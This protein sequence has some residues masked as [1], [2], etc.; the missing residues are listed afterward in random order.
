M[1]RLR[2]IRSLLPSLAGRASTSTT[3]ASLVKYLKQRENM[4]NERQSKHALWLI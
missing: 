3:H 4:A 2:G 1:A